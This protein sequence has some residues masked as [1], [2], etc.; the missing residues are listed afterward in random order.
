MEKPVIELHHTELL[1]AW[2][3]CFGQDWNLNIAYAD[4]GSIVEIVIVDA[5]TSGAWPIPQHAT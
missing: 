1:E 5:K 2:H 4:G 3:G